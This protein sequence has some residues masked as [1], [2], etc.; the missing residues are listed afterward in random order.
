MSELIGEYV[1][2]I[3]NKGRLMI[4]SD[5]R[6]QLPNVEDEGLIVLRGFEKQLT[7]YPKSEWK[8]KVDKLS[9]L[10][11]YDKKSRHFL[12]Y[13]TRGAIPLKVDGTGRVLFPKQLLDYAGITNEMT[14]T[15]LLTRIEAWDT[16]T[17]NNMMNEMPEDFSDMAQDLMDRI[18]GGPT[19]E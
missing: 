16:T 2:K 18:E 10:S 3:D 15:C 6:Q 4:P 14:L 5:L 13:L 1:C 9:K 8:S 17:Y 11:E 19:H 7:L 12:R